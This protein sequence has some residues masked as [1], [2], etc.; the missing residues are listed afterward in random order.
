MPSVLPDSR[1]RPS[2]LKTTPRTGLGCAG[3]VR[4]GCPVSAALTGI[5]IT[6]DATLAA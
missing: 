5:K 2:A 6:L 1:R 3:S 4:T